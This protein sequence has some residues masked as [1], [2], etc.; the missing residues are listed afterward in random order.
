MTKS[1]RRTRSLEQK[2]NAEDQNADIL[3]PAIPGNIRSLLGDPPLLPGEDR[4]AYDTLMGAV[5][6]DLNPTGVMEW[7]FVEDFVYATLAIRTLRKAKTE[8][9]RD[10][11]QEAL[12][13]AFTETYEMDDRP[14]D[15]AQHMAKLEAG[16]F[17]ELPD[18]HKEEVVQHLGFMGLTL[19]S[20]M[21]RGL[22]RRLGHIDA[23]ERMI[24]M[25]LSRRESA[26]RQLD[27]L[28]GGM[29][30]RLRAATQ[31]VLDVDPKTGEP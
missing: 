2:S 19:D 24:S 15:E 18:H 16:R 17:Q 23:I 8:L 21:A 1:A 20:V 31:D 5:S 10:G 4:K 29:G 9:L 14:P 3:A 26:L 28:R 7:T 27:A 13:E 11:R 12:A 30:R 22:V 25:Y 6:R